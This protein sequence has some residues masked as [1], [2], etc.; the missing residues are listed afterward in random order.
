MMFFWFIIIGVLIYMLLGDN[1]SFDKFQKKT[2]LDL[3]DERLAKGEISIEEYREL[4]EI[5]KESKR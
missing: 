1:L 2:S 4:K 3:L 5:L